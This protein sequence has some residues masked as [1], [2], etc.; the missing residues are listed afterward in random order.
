MFDNMQ[1]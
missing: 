1:M